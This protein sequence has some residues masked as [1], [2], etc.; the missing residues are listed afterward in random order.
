MN[1]PDYIHMENL[2]IG[3]ITN[4]CRNDNV[5]REKEMS[6]IIKFM[7][8]MHVTAVMT[9]VGAVLITAKMMNDDQE[10]VEQRLQAVRSLIQAQ[11]A[12]FSMQ[13]RSKVATFVQEHETPNPF[14]EATPS[15]SQ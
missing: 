5:N 6:D 1:R 12:E 7:S 13:L 9:L 14:S 15:N 10:G 8:K 11:D 2:I 3:A 4:I